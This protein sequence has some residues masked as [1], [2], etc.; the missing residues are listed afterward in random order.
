MYVLGEF[1]LLS[2]LL[3]AVLSVWNSLTSTLK[4]DGPIR[5]I[6]IIGSHQDLG[7]AIL[8]VWAVG[9]QPA[10][11][12]GITTSHAWMNVVLNGAIV[13]GFIPLKD[14]VISMVSKGL[15]A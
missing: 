2:A 12:W 14:A 9:V 1:L 11:G 4:L 10:A 15:R 6:P 13:Y 5:M 3:V 8:M 7:M